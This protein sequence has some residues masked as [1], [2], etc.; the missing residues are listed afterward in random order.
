MEQIQAARKSTSHSNRV[1]PMSVT[2][3]CNIRVLQA[4]GYSTS[5]QNHGCN[6]RDAD[7]R[8]MGNTGGSRPGLPPP[9][10]GGSANKCTH[11]K[12]NARTRIRSLFPDTYWHRYIITKHES[13]CASAKVQV[14][15]CANASTQV[16]E[17][18]NVQACKCK[19]MSAKRHFQ[20][21]SC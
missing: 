3:K 6:N 4:R 18:A 17:Y 8:Q 9:S 21:S 2:L 7:T 1:L 16:C 11:D 20:T 13:K 5:V 10:R 15:K 12:Y 19:C 14:C